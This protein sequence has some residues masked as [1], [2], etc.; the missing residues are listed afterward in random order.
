MSKAVFKKAN[1]TIGEL[2]NKA[3]DSEYKNILLFLVVFFIC[4]IGFSAYSNIEQ[5]KKDCSEPITKECASNIAWSS[6]IMI[7]RAFGYNFEVKN[8]ENKS[9]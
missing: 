6:M 4:A 9:Q 2:K 5:L 8:T 7:P 3:N 1:K